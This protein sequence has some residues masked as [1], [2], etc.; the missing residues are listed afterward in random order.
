MCSRRGGV[1]DPNSLDAH[2]Q[3]IDLDSLPVTDQLGRQDH[4]V[5]HV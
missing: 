1:A 4:Q 5:G 2:S 3:T